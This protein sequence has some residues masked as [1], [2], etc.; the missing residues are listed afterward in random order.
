MSAIYN[1]CAG[2]AMLPQAVMQKAQQELINWNGLGVSVMEI[3]HRSKEFM[4]LTQHAEKTL[5]TLMDIPKNYHVLF[6]HGGGRGQFTNVVNNFLGDNGKALYLVN[7]QWSTAAV[8]EAIKLVGENNIDQVNIIENIDGL[9]Q[10]VL[11]DFSAHSD[12]YRYL[13]FCA[14]ETV[15]GIE[16]FDEIECPW[17]VV[18]DLS[19]TIMSRK[20][21]VSKY[22]LI[23]AG[24]QKNIGPS[25]L[26]IVIVRDDMLQLPSLPQSSIMDYR[27]A[28]ANDSMF[29]TPPTFAWY[30]A[31]EVFDWLTS[32]GGVAAMEALNQQKAQMLYD[33]I[34]NNPFYTNGVCKQNRSRMNVTFQLSDSSLDSEFLAQAEQAG[35]VALKGHRVVGGMRASIYNAMPLA[36][37][38]ALVDFMQAFAK[39]HS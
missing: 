38:Q 18:V 12:D 10:V 22:G 6:M 3:S 14:N 27:I 16:I 20:I 19:S 9:N 37:V 39:Q 31:A 7:G 15:D 25:G 35:L 33:C 32:V 29:N 13:H 8:K 21:D 26:S 28:Q 23:Y 5:R 1:F 36:G 24:A 30:L 2:P 4:A 11:P 34:D 17:P